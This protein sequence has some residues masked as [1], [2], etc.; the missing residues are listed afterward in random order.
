MVVELVKRTGRELEHGPQLHVFPQRGD[1]FS[2]QQEYNGVLHRR[3]GLPEPFGDR[4]FAYR[5]RPHAHHQGYVT[6]QLPF[7]RGQKV[8]LRQ[9][10]C[11]CACRRMANQRTGGLHHRPAF[12]DRSATSPYYPCGA[13]SIPN[14]HPSGTF[15]PFS[16]SGFSA[17]DSADIVPRLHLP[18]YSSIGCNLSHQVPQ[19]RLDPAGLT[20]PLCA[21]LARRMRT[22]A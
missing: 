22:P 5:L 16:P 15:G 6:Y 10:V 8:G 18:Y 7:G 14:F 19:R 4:K 2:A 13:I 3:A 11:E 12:P 1:T 17:V 20:T 21:A 9:G